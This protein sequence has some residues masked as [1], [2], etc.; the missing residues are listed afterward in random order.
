MATAFGA[1]TIPSTSFTRAIASSE[2][3][4]T[5]GRRSSPPSSRTTSAVSSATSVPP[6]SEMPTSATASAGASLMPSP[7]IATLRPSALRRRTTSAF[8]SGRTSPMASSMPQVRAMACTGASASPE[9]RST[10]R[11]PPARRA[12]DHVPALGARGVRVADDAGEL[13]VDGHHDAGGAVRRHAVAD[14]QGGAG[15]DAGLAHHAGVADHHPVAAH[16]RLE[17]EADAVVLAA[18]LQRPRGRA[19]GHRVPAEGVGDGVRLVALGGGGAA[20]RCR[21][22]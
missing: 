14:G 5:S 16:A 6:R 12:R 19:D 7:T 3:S 11:R 10:R 9:S 15:I 4:S 2:S 20:R 21:W 17:A 1:S 18:L 22:C 8:C 13:P